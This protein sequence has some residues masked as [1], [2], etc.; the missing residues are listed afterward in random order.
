M[1]DAR[2]M[3][4][5]FL[6]DSVLFLHFSRVL[7]VCLTGWYLTKGLYYYYVWWNCNKRRKVVATLN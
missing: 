6:Y 7:D 5:Y 3:D 4:K 1:I 2:A